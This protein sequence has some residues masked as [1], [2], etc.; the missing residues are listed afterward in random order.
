M[1]PQSPGLALAQAQARLQIEAFI[2]LTSFC[3]L[4]QLLAKTCSK[5]VREVDR[6]GW[7]TL[8]L[9]ASFVPTLADL[10]SSASKSGRGLPRPAAH[11]RTPAGHQ[12]TSYAGPQE[13]GK[14]NLI[15]NI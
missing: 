2:A 7:A 9:V 8:Q 6:N 1:A 5:S 10:E 11:A 3:K 15:F 12:G 14:K 4:F 13:N